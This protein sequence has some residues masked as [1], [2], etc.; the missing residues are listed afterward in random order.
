MD[1]LI[2]QV[3]EQRVN[4][5]RFTV[6]GRDVSLAGAATFELG[7][8]QDLPAVAARIASGI[9]GSPRVVL[10]LPPELFAQRQ[11]ELPL[12][13]LR[14]V[15]EVLPV[16]LQGEIALQPGEAVFDA[17]PSGDGRF[18]ALWGRHA[19]LD[20][21]ITL[22]RDAG[23]E[24]QIVSSALFAWSFLPG[25]G[26]E[27]LVSDGSAVA[28]FSA[29]RPV[30]LRSLG[31]GD[32]LR[33]L[34]GTISALELSGMQLPPALT[35]FGP[36]SAHLA[37]GSLSR[38]VQRLELPEELGTVFR[39]DDN[40]QKLA[41]MFAV[42][43]ACHAGALPDF[44]RGDLAWT[45]GDARLR[46]KLYLTAALSAAVVVLLFAYQGISYQRARTDLASLDGSIASIYREIFPGRT[47]AVD[48]LSEVKGEL[49]KLQGTD[50][51][52][53]F[54]DLLKRLA[55]AKGGTINGLYEA[56]LEGNVLRIKGDARSA[57]AANEFRTA[58]EPVMT[59][60]EMGEVKGRPDG[61]VS[62]S[63]SGTVREVKP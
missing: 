35:V 60:I 30:L 62:F 28:L 48:E 52:S 9:T 7:G 63:M 14:K 34:E 42:A 25:L 20:G 55:D 31:T 29:G 59:A 36:L 15:R 8:E 50:G 24:P 2:L 12:D 39:T 49:R 47:K 58:L 16:H 53:G 27:S 18:L 22:F 46:R 4:V 37:D 19:D 17:L 44:R 43:R 45:A 6:G 13:D 3:E 23:V 57:Q 40:F 26:Q 10:C 38:P 21:A 5:A 54:L 56:E 61:T 1:Y 33:Q 41:A 51:S 11:V 32:P